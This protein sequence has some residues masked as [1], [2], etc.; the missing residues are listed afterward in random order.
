MKVWIFAL[1]LCL[2]ASLGLAQTPAPA[3]APVLKVSP[4]TVQL[5]AGAKQTFSASETG[6]TSPSL[7]WSLSGP[8]GATGSL[9]A[10]DSTGA[11]VAPAVPPVPATVT[12]TATD[13][14]HNL[15]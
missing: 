15:S 2:A 12:V 13:K 7:T 9:G 8:P 14:A 4:A 6:V 10:I 11:Y 3:T 5:R 1:Y